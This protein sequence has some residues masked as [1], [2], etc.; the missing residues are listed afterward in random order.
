[1]ESNLTINGRKINYINYEMFLDL[2]LPIKEIRSS[3]SSKSFRPLVSSGV[4]KWNITVMD[5]Y[6]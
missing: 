3:Y 4:K 1:M 5:K 2:S 6:M